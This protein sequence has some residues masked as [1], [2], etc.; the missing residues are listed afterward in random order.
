M[1]VNIKNNSFLVYQ[2]LLLFLIL[3][4]SCNERTNLHPETWIVKGY[5][6]GNSIS[7]FTNAGA[8]LYIN[9]IVFVSSEKVIIFG[10]TCHN[11]IINIDKRDSFDLLYNE[12]AETDCSILPDDSTIVMNIMCK[13][14]PDYHNR[15]SLS[16]NYSIFRLSKSEAIIPVNGVYFLLSKFN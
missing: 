7:A 3:S 15:D 13:T 2:F 8:K 1:T 16:F 9:K 10:D 12:Y 6:T 4:I 5:K 14:K 11:P